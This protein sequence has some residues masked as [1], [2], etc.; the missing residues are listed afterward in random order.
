M[1][2]A[3]ESDSQA[4]TPRRRRFWYA[5]VLGI[6]HCV[7]RDRF[8]EGSEWE[9]I[10]FLWIRWMGADPDSR[11]GLNARRL[12]RVG[13]V[14]DVDG[15]GAFGFIDPADV[16]RAS[17]LVPAFHHGTRADL[18]SSS[19]SVAFDFNGPEGEDYEFYYILR[20][21]DRDMAMRNRGGGVGHLD[22]N[23]VSSQEEYAEPKI[24][25]E[26]AVDGSGDNEVQSDEIDD[27]WP[28]GDLE[29]DEELGWEAG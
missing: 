2:V 1:L 3:D 24:S 28:V 11:S 10:D 14:P 27:A 13:Y 17:H 8:A 29:T 15:P 18:L 12:E 20:F 16:V 19:Q 6:F 25:E 26:A 5:R 4:S 22:A 21:S 23:Q 9:R 7:A